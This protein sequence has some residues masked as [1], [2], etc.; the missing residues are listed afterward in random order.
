M[1]RR[2]EQ[3]LTARASSK[4]I[5]LNILFH[6]TKRPAT[7]KDFKIRSISKPIEVDNLHISQPTR[8]ET[9]PSQVFVSSERKNNYLLFILIYL[10]F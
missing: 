7:S 8:I 2:D 3:L 1:V 9:R 6:T 5:G 10:P 4:A